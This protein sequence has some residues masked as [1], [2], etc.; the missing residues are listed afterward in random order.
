MTIDNENNIIDKENPP[1]WTQIREDFSVPKA[2]DPAYNGFLEL[3]FNYQGLIALF[4]HR[5]AHRLYKRGFKLLGRI[6]MGWAQFLTSMDIHPAAYIGRRVF[7]DHGIGVVIGE[8]AQIGNDVTIYQG[9]SLGGVSLEKTKRH[10]TLM[11]NVVVGAGAKILGNIVVGE[12]A[13]IGSN[14]VVVK[15]VPSNA[16][17][18]GI[19]A[20]I[21][22]E[23]SKKD[24]IE[25]KSADCKE[26]VTTKLP[27]IDKKM[28]E[29]ILCRLKIL[30]SMLQEQNLDST[31]CKE[32]E[33]LKEQL[34]K[35]DSIYDEFLKA[36]KK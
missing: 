9:V 22:G 17:A 36:I 19:P 7:I 26:L 30:E 12:N 28:F 11:N 21:I 31:K 35:L 1:F 4:H 15:N 6:I 33:N 23:D 32:Y 20:R 24:S 3:F 27:D 29:Y 34:D 2:K 18:V 16:T 14:S 8:T 13:K 25:S 5:I 10:P